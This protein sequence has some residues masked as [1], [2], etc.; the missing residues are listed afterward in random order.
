M[1][2][3]NRQS[4]GSLGNGDFDGASVDPLWYKPRDVSVV[5]CLLD[6]TL[7]LVYS[8][9]GGRVRLDERGVH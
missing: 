4:V 1:M 5:D 7:F 2:R 9:L 8:V 6:M 3:R